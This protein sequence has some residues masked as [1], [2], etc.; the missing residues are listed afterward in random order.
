MLYKKKPIIVEAVQWTG[1]N[2]SAVI[3]FCSAARRIWDGRKIAYLL[4]PTLVGEDYKVEKGDWVIKDALG[5]F[6]SCKNDI[7]IQTY[8]KA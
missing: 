2:T 8:E 3:Q 4:I 7:F 1:K 6:Y 5:E